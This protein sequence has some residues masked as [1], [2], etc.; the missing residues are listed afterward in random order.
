MPRKGQNS[1]FDKRHFVIYHREK[2]KNYREI[3]QLLI[4]EKSTVAN[5][6]KKYKEEDC[7]K[8]KKKPPRI[9]NEKEERIIIW[10][11]EEEIGRE[12]RKQVSVETVQDLM[13][14]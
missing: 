10:R 13:V 12:T 9:I 14:E 4:M 1:S 6:I 2:G 11:V 3:A 8:F 5:I 7:I